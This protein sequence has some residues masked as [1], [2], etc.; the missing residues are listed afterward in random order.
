MSKYS[1]GITVVYLTTNDFFCIFVNNSRCEL[2]VYEN[3]SCLAPALLPTHVHLANTK[4]GI[5]NEIS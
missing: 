1:V 3:S 2:E 4:K 5:I